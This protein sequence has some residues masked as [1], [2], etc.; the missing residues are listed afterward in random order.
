MRT[1]GLVQGVQIKKEVSNLSLQYQSF[2]FKQ[3]NRIIFYSD[4]CK[5]RTK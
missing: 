2:K 3:T 5:L 1:I 4:M